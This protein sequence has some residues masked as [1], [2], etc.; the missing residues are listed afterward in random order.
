MNEEGANI[1]RLWHE[2]PHEEQAMAMDDIRARAH[3]FDQ[4]VRRWNQATAA[5]ILA[6]IVIEVWQIS[7]ER[8]QIERLGDFLTVVAFIYVGYRYRRS[9]A[10]TSP[11]GPALTTSV[12]FYRQQ[13]A[14]QRD[15]SHNPWAFLL[16][17]VPGVALSLFGSALDWSTADIAIV[18]V[19]AVGLFVGAA[20]WIKRGERRLQ[21]EIDELG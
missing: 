1:R 8:E 16:P 17:F 7:I 5:L 14:R 21:R 15:L 10:D 2:Q 6:V 4:R 13:L 18:A 19:L 20:W 3:R 12:D 11:A 9:V